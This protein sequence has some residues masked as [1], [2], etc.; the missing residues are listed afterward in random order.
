VKV[1]EREVGG[2]AKGAEEI[3]GRASGRG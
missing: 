1:E 2:G 3:D